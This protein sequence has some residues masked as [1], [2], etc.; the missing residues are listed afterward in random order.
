MAQY[1]PLFP[2][3][4]VVFPGEELRLYIFEP[5]YK[6]LIQE[7]NQDEIT[8]GIPTVIEKKLA[9]LF[10]EI[11]LVS[12]D[13]IYP[14]GEMDV[15]TLGIRR[16]KLLK[17]DRKAPDKLYPGGEVE[18]ME[19]E[20]E[21][22]LELQVEVLKLL[23]S[24]NQV[25]GITKTYVKDP[26]DLRSFDIGH[27]VGFTLQQEYK[28]L[29]IDSETDRLMYIK[30]HIHKILPMVKETERLKARAKMNGHYKNI[31]PPEF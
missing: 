25:L 16:G 29:G 13:R 28:L 30:E 8:F 11:Q 31:I 22:D 26:I 6:Q 17:F 21:Q 27:Q 24:L 10:T 9:L 20:D 1:L 4:S 18:W 12:I 2:L 5:R 7:C 14:A 15:R 19:T 23:E 3:S